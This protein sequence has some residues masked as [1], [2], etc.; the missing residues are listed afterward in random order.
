M[1]SKTT[2]KARKFELEIDRSFLELIYT[3]LMGNCRV[4]IKFSLPDNDL[5]LPK[6]SNQS[7][8]N[9]IDH[10]RRQSLEKDYI[11][12][13]SKSYPQ[14]MSTFF[15]WFYPRRDSAHLSLLSG[16]LLPAIDHI[17]ALAEVK[18]SKYPKNC[19][20]CHR[21]ENWYHILSMQVS[22]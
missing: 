9:L 3:N 15:P 1:L 12:I 21:N 19:L 18:S 20:I 5:T 17:N 22:K 16:N 11:K 6:P 10:I 8:N 13:L 7:S 14:R 2:K 4:N